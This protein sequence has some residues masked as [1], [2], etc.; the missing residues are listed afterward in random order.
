MIIGIVDYGMGN[1]ASVAGAIERLGH[2]PLVTTL[3][4]E[5]DKADRLILPGVGAFADAM[6]ELRRRNL[7]ETLHDLVFERQ[8]PLLGICLGAQLLTLESDEF[9]HN[10]GLGWLKAR[11]LRLAP[12]DPAL[13]VPHVGWN[14]LFPLQDSPLLRDV[15]PGSLFY[16][17]HS[18]CI[19]ADEPGIVVG[20][21]DY[22]GRFAAV[23]QS[24]NICATQFHP[25]KS[26]KPGLQ[27]LRNF[28]ERT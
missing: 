13:R 18:Y 7:V 27:I 5:L 4:D 9:G 28:I 12:S 26:Q 15:P 1:L 6:D 21:C 23:L 25:E 2:T 24:G 11:T 17:V 3:R 14:D 10:R 8:R 16:Y 22:G 19:R 20:E